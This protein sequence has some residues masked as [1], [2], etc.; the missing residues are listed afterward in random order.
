MRTIER[1]CRTNPRAN[2]NAICEGFLPRLR[3]NVF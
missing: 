1:K 2:G 3:L